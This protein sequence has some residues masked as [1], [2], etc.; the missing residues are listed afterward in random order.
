MGIQWDG[1]GM[2]CF[3]MGWHRK[4][5]P[6]D[7]PAYKD[8][9]TTIQQST[10]LSLRIKSITFKQYLNF[11]GDASPHRDLASPHGGLSAG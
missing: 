1:T 5:C 2:N 7:K 11:K 8:L 3:G 6:T 4:I 10:F 9:Q